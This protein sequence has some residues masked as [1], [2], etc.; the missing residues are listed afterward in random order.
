MSNQIKQ[1]R[2]ASAKVYQALRDTREG[3]YIFLSVGATTEY[4]RCP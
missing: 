4:V 1:T 3:G 2:E